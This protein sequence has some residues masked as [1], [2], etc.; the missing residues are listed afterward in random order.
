MVYGPGRTGRS[1]GLWPWDEMEL[2]LE[3]IF[4]P[5]AHRPPAW[6]PD[7]DVFELD[8]EYLIYV[9]VPGLE[10]EQIDLHLQGTTLTVRGTRPAPIAPE[11]FCHVHER[12][13]GR[14]ERR[15][16]LPDPVDPGRVGAR[17]RDGVLEVRVR[18]SRH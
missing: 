4:Q 16:T 18:K 6:K 14:F 5:R 11:G 10:A 8:D 3:R 2:M 17:C 7:I 15:I 13:F 12:S 9:D 1:G